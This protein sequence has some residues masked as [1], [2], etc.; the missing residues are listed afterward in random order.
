MQREIVVTLISTLGTV[1]VAFL[2][3]RGSARRD[4]RP[5]VGP[6]MGLSEFC[7][8]ATGVARAAMTECDKAFQG[9]TEGDYRAPATGGDR[10]TAYRAEA[11]LDDPAPV[12]AE[13]HD[14][15]RSELDTYAKA[16]RAF[17]QK[18]RATGRII[19][20]L[21]DAVPLA[22][23]HVEREL[24]RHL[25]ALRESLQALDAAFE[26]SVDGYFQ[27]HDSFMSIRARRSL[28][29]KAENR[30]ARCVTAGKNAVLEESQRSAADGSRE[31]RV[32]QT[33]VDGSR[34]V[35]GYCIW[36]CPHA[37][38]LS[39]I[40]TTARGAGD[41]GPSAQSPASAG[42]H[43]VGSG[44]RGVALPAARGVTR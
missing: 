7:G 38:D 13:A 28:R 14:L 31:D 8:Y 21:A 25:P 35:C 4:H 1:W 30:Y 39:F 24:G 43:A 22:P 29:K 17:Q 9:L 5:Y 23:A 27:R 34:P 36:R 2:T 18:L 32:D 44:G 11:G 41:P 26:N 15:V 37:P 12:A 42:P 40:P 16:T 10:V 20:D 6:L 19:D 3:V 33:G